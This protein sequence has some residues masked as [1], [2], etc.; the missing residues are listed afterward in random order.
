MKLV[1]KLDLWM[2]T[3]F[4]WFYPKE[5]QREFKY[6]LESVFRLPFRMLYKKGGEAQYVSSGVSSVNYQG[7]F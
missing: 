4:I 6:E 1:Q 2:Y 5:Y 7:A 3:Q